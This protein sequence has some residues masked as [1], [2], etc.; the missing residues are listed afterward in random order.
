MLTGGFPCQSWSIA[1][2]KQGLFDETGRLFFEII[3]LIKHCKPKALF[4]EN[5][6]N[7][8]YLDNG[9]NWNLLVQ[10]LEDAGYFVHYKIISAHTWV[11][12][13]RRRMYIVCL[14]KEKIKNP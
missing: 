3:R 7:L 1:G 13:T 6:P 11:P 8:L 2:D 4:L 10:H 5:V 9:D 14:S 12:Q